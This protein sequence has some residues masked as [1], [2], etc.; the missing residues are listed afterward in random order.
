[1]DYLVRMNGQLSCLVLDGKIS[2]G[3]ALEEMERPA[4]DAE[5]LRRD[6][7]FVAKKLGLTEGELDEII[8]LPRKTFWDY[9]SN[10]NGTAGSGSASCGRC[11]YGSDAEADAGVAGRLAAPVPLTDAEE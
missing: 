1:V 10:E 6:R 2:R 4:I 9:P 3:Q 7:V 5:E 11:S 8:R